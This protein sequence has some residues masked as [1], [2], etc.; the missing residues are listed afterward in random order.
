VLGT[1]LPG[2]RLIFPCQSRTRFAGVMRHAESL[3]V[4]EL[5]K[6][7]VDHRDGSL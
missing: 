6:T 1:R 5:S 7:V 2:P 3:A 4:L